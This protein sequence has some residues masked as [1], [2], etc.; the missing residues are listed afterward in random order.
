[1]KYL[2]EIKS[3]VTIASVVV[4]MVVSTWGLKQ[5]SEKDRLRDN[6]YH[7]EVQ[8]K[9]KEGRLVTEV[10]ELK[11]SREELRKISKS[12]SSKLSS[13]QKELYKV[14]KELEVLGIKT[15]DVESYNKAKLEVKYDSL[16][17]NVI[18]DDKG[19]ITELEPIKTDNLSIDFIVKTDS[20][21]VNYKYKADVTAILNRKVDK[22]TYKGKKRFF[23]ARLIN[24]RYSYWSTN[25]V[26]D[27]NA[28]I[29]SDVYINFG[30]F[31][32]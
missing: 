4:A 19:C 16:V 15:K 29:K 6:L 5:Q 11:Y 26:S 28:E 31:N 2:D 24:P 17:S 22:F 7:K 20:V 9:D 30:R 23:L 25:V 32:K 12:D 13:T 21:L 3:T 27:P 10:T 1:V 14:A 8:W 18:K